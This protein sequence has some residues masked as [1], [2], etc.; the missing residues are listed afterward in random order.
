MMVRGSDGEFLKQLQWKPTTLNPQRLL[1]IQMIAVQI[2]LTSAIAEVEE[3]V[4]RVEGKVE[5]L[6]QLAEASRAG[7]VIGHNAAVSRTLRFVE[8]NGSLPDAMWDAVAGLGP[9]LSAAVERLRNHVTRSIASLDSVLPVKERAELLNRV[10]RDNKVAETLDLLVVAEETLYKWQSVLVARVGESEPD[11]LADVIRDSR[12]LLAAQLQEDGRLYQNAKAMIDRVAR[13]EDIEGFRLLSLQ[14]LARD[15]QILSKALDGF[16]RARRHQLET[17]ED[18]ERPDPLDA[19]SAAANKMRDAASAA[20]DKMI[21]S[22]SRAITGAGER[23]LKA[24]DRLAERQRL[25]EANKPSAAVD[26][27]AD[28]Q[29]DTDADLPKS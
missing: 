16:A 14:K 11:H 20:T 7:D 6:L 13:A 28:H 21:E 18:F 4:R 23:L 27:S 22:T 26:D 3:S 29:P 17:W 9:T 2:A 1:S 15:R 24:G 5:A 12:E 8:T 19:A 10:V 25:R